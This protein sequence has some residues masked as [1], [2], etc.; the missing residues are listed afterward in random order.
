MGKVWDNNFKKLCEFK[1]LHG[2]TNVPKSF[3][4]TKLA[5]LVISL[6]QQKRSGSLKPERELALLQLGFDFDPLESKWQSNYKSVVEFYRLN[7]HASPNR[8]S[9]NEHERGLAEWVHRMHKLV[10]ECELDRDKV[11]Q[12]QLINIDGN[13]AEYRINRDGLPRV[14]ASFIERL[15]SQIA[16]TGSDMH[17]NI[18]DQGL[19][20]W[21]VLQDERINASLITPREYTTLMHT[22]FTLEIAATQKVVQFRQKSA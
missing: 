22:G 6:R 5:R 11:R 7:G 9:D 3:E 16:R 4:D 12:L 17:S 15:N 8:R 19:Y 21:L 14:F 10:R 18:T 13:P 20:Q 1:N 2:H